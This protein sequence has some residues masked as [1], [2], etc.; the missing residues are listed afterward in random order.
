LKIWLVEFT[1]A[2]KRED[3]CIQMDG[4]AIG[5]M[6]PKRHKERKSHPLPRIKNDL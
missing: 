1:A 5:E 4:D 2:A 6:F 3:H